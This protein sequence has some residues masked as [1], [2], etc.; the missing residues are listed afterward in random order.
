MS[1][2][3]PIADMLTRIRN[4]CQAKH[5]KVEM[6]SSKIKKD[7]ARILLEQKFISNFVYVEDQ[8][9]GILKIYLK[10]GPDG[11]PVI[12]SFRRVSKPG[13][14][15]YVDTT[16]IPRVLNGLGIAILTTPKGIL[17]DR[18]ARRLHTG[19]EVLCH[20]W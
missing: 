14:R 2:T 1:M 10:Y 8:K 5:A 19:G 13:R 9:Q 7:I 11:E 15:I 6:P 16:E 4:A 17:T 18:E 12:S 3:D 20:V